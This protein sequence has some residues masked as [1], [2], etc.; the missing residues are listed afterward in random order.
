M[1]GIMYI[2]NDM[3]QMCKN[4]TNLYKKKIIN[5]HLLSISNKIIQSCYALWFLYTWMMMKQISFHVI[6]CYNRCC[7]F[8]FYLGGWLKIDIF[9]DGFVKNNHTFLNKRACGEV[10]CI[11]YFRWFNTFPYKYF[12]HLYMEYLRSN[13]MKWIV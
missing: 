3:A 2:L 12:A 11:S 7:Q 4:F 10:I 13:K 5:S 8:F 6:H 1:N 9:H